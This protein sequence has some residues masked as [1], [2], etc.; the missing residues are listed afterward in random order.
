MCEIWAR[1]LLYVLITAWHWRRWAR[2]DVVAG[3]KRANLPNNWVAKARGGQSGS[4]VPTKLSC[5]RA[6]S[7]YFKCADELKLN[8]LRAA[9]KLCKL[10]CSW[11]AKW[12]QEIP[13]HTQLQQ[14]RGHGSSRRGEAQLACNGSRQQA[15]GPILCCP[16]VSCRFLLRSGQWQVQQELFPAD[17]KWSRHKLRIELTPATLLRPSLRSLSSHLRLGDKLSCFGSWTLV[18]L[19]RAAAFKPSA[20]VAANLK[21]KAVHVPGSGCGQ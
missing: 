8:I 2:I 11:L 16:L 9:L 15:A 18:Y 13:A 14:V 7:S 1:G 10:I 17:R 12:W 19:I 3:S 5:Q 21:A 4:E 20:E 6:L